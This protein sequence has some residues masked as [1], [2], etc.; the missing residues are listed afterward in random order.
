MLNLKNIRKDIENYCEDLLL[1][2]CPYG[3]YLNSK[4]GRCDLYSSADIAIMRHITGEDLKKLDISKRTQ[5]INHINSYAD[6]YK[7]DGSYTDTHGHSPLH[8][9]GMVIGALGVL[10]GKQKY[11]NRLYDEFCDV[12]KI[13]GWLSGIDW[14]NQWPV[15][16]LFWG[17]M[18]CFSMSKHCTA[19]WIDCVFSWLDKNNCE[20][21]G[22]WKKGASYTDRHQQL[23]GFVHIVPM[24]QH[25]GREFKHAKKVIDSVLALQ[26]DRG[27][28]LSWGGEH[29]MHYLELDALYALKYMR[30]LEPCYRKDDIEKAIK[31]YILLVFDYYINSKDKL[32]S[33][34]PHMVLGAVGCFGLLNQLGFLDDE[35]AWTDIFSDINLYKTA[36]VEKE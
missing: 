30:S 6:E 2:G 3:S 4:D 20:K 32:F 10:G 8:A 34:H 29:V 16:H 25:H 9:N 36:D 12:N 17:G 27:S 11:K 33:Q 1:N 28:W 35:T 14:S 23:G 31:K 18:H 13:E 24:Y 21:T 26:L 5:W 7:K 22:F 15:S 19:E